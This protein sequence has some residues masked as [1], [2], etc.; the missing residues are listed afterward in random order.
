METAECTVLS[1]DSEDEDIVLPLSARVKG[2]AGQPPA[3]EGKEAKSNPSSGPS[4]DVKT[5]SRKTQAGAGN[6]ILP[7][8]S[9]VMV[10]DAPEVTK[11]PPP[12]PVADEGSVD[13]RRPEFELVP[14]SFE[15]VLVV[16]SSESTAS[17]KY[18]HFFL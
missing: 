2:K 9:G 1:S 7:H 4:N 14:W 16:D 15:V 13:L 11:K 5:T 17:R 10:S 6:K 18:D 12:P 3:S 8:A